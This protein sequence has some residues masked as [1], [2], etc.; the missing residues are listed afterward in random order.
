MRDVIETIANNSAIVT[1]GDSVMHQVTDMMYCNLYR[2]GFGSIS[3]SAMTTEEKSAF[4]GM[5]YSEYS[6]SNYWRLG[7]DVQRTT[8]C[9]A[10]THK[11]VAMVWV[12]SY[13]LNTFARGAMCIC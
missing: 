8:F 13:K 12:H 3:R 10:E 2:N 9:N 7:I 6:E 11:C 1:V 5:N 4:F